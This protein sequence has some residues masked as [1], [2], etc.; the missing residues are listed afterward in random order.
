MKCG[1]SF[2][3]DLIKYWGLAELHNGVSYDV[4][5]EGM[6]RLNRLTIDEVK[7]VRKEQKERQT[8]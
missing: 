4:V 5:K 1:G 6:K 3:Q 8:I 7:Q 2:K